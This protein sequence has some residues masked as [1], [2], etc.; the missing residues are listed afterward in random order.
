MVLKP[1]NKVLSTTAFHCS[2]T[3][4]CGC[5]SGGGTLQLDKIL[6]WWREKN[7]DSC[8]RLILVLDSENSLPW[9][10]E[11][12]KVGGLYVAVQG[13]QLARATDIELQDTP[14]LGDF[15]SQWV[16]YNCNADSTVQWSERGRTVTAAYGISKHWSDYTLHLPTESDVTQHWRMY[17]PRMTYP[18]VQLALWCGGLNLLWLCSVCLRCLKRVKLNWFPP[19]ILDTGQG[20]KLVKS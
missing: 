20:F 1:Q 6:E 12:R 13:A 7:N 14:Q 10:K 15:T 9:V 8:S 2:L 19:A 3:L 5:L 11:V 4:P 17:F 18:V 16:E